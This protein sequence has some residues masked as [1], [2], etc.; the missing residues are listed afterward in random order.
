MYFGRTILSA[1]FAIWSGRQR[2]NHAEARDLYELLCSCDMECDQ[3]D[4][5]FGALYD[6]LTAKWPELQGIDATEAEFDACPWS[7]PITLTD[8]YLIVSCSWPW[9]S[10][11]QA[12]LT[13][14]ARRHGLTLYDPQSGTVFHPDGTMSVPCDSPKTKPPGGIPGF[15]VGCVAGWFPGLFIAAFYLDTF[16]EHSGNYVVAVF[17]I[18]VASFTCGQLGGSLYRRLRP[19]V[20]H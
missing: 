12:F 6:D 19:A 3:S 15:F 9:V 11:V 17:L 20:P 1:D 8:S 13:D 18:L 7:A 14:Q 4:Q 16:P 5:A 2:L 10:E